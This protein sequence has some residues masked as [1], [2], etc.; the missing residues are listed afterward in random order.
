MIKGINIFTKKKIFQLSF[1]ELYQIITGTKIIPSDSPIKE[2]HHNKTGPSLRRIPHRLDAVGGRKSGEGQQ[3][4]LTGNR[5]A[6]GAPA[7]VL[8]ERGEGAIRERAAGGRAE[9]D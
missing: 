5:K 4:R 1:G 7:R 3:S 6:G 8:V 9:G 2:S